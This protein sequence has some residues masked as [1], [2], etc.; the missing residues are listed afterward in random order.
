MQILLLF[1]IFHFIGDFIVQT[2]NHCEQKKKR[3]SINILHSFLYSLS[4][5]LATIWFASIWQSLLIVVSIGISHFLIDLTKIKLDK[6]TKNQSF[7]FLLFLF[8]QFLHIGIL[9]F[10]SRFFNELN[11]LGLSLIDTI[12]DFIGHDI[13]LQRIAVI[14]LTYIIALTPSSIFVRHFFSFINRQEMECLDNLE[15][16][17]LSQAEK[18]EL[19]KKQIEKRMGSVIGMLE[20]LVIITLGI[21]GLYTSIALVITAKSIARF[22]QLENKDF[23]EKYLVGTLL[24]LLIAILL[25]LLIRIF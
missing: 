17:H 4:I 5:L 16:E 18:I 22:K 9:F 6:L 2:E 8:D 10:I 1:L 12:R 23:A 11:S 14:I 21:M 19:E 13:S 7:K 24:S 25:I 3:L 20:R 15:A